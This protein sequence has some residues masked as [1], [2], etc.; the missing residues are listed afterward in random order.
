MD[1][2]ALLMIDMQKGFLHPDGTMSWEDTESVIQNC[3]KAL[4]TARQN[5]LST[6]G[7]LAKAEDFVPSK[8]R[9]LLV[10]PPSS[11]VPHLS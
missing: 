10:F 4:Q 3:L 8:T 2:S 6:L 11:S 7:L 5:V 9:Y 1:N